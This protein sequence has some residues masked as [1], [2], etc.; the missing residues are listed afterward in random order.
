MY[1]Y[2]CRHLIL[3]AGKHINEQLTIVIT[4]T[5]FLSSLPIFVFL[6]EDCVISC[7]S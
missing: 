1:L 7:I 2:L 3:Q 6:L 5:G 4:R